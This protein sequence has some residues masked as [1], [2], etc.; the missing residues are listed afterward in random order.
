MNSIYDNLLLLLIIMIFSVLGLAC[1]RFEKFKAV[2]RQAQHPSQL[3][4]K[5]LAKPILE[6]WTVNSASKALH[7]LLSTRAKH[8]GNF[9]LIED[10]AQQHTVPS[11]RKAGYD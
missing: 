7:K 2:Y 9:N 8:C 5:G 4:V 10:P 1:N 6:Q 3:H 11:D